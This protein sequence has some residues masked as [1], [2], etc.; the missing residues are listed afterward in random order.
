MFNSIYINIPEQELILKIEIQQKAKQK[1]NKQKLHDVCIYIALGYSGNIKTYIQF[2][3]LKHN[4]ALR[5]VKQ[6][7]KG[8]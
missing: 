7:E 1:T 8:F 6:G 5:K 4:K 2:S 3:M